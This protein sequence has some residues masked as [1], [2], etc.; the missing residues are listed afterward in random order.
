MI[1]HRERFAGRSVGL[2]LC[3]GNID[4]RLLA[5]VLTRALV[6]EQ[7]IVR[8]RIVGA[9]RPGLLASVAT[10][11]GML[12]GNILEVAHNRLALEVP[13]KGAEFDVLM[14]TRDAH[15]TQEIL[16]ELASPN[17]SVRIV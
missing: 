7:R 4:S 5:T 3:G 13:A 6:R 8:L 14:E 16:S 17:Y 9:D 10:T 11:I 15:H 2:V 12:G 1:A